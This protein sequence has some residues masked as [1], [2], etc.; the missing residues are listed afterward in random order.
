MKGKTLVLCKSDKLYDHFTERFLKLGFEDIT[1]SG[2]EWDALYMLIR[3]MKPNNILIGSS[4]FTCCTPFVISEVH[5]RFK[6]INIAGINLGNYPADYGMY[7]IVN[8]AKSY[9]NL[10]DGLPEFY[11]GINDV[12][13][14]REYISPTVQQRF[15]IRE[16]YPK[17]SKKFSLRQIYIIKLICN[18]FTE[19]EIAVEMGISVNTVSTQ[20]RLIYTNSNSRNE[21]EVFKFALLSKIVTEDDL[22]FYPRDL[23]LKPKPENKKDKRFLNK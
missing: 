3:D 23:E 10:T 22:I 20:K 7:F 16:A 13:E 8:G 21:R 17:P 4:Y 5:K 2:A 11:K 6:K 18:G 9:V 12:S 15:S 19:K 1:M 14:G